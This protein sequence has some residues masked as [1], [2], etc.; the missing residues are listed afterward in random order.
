MGLL[1]GCE[2]EARMSFRYLR[3]AFSATCLIAC[4]LL[5][6]LWVRSYWRVDQLWYYK[7]TTMRGVNS[8]QGVITAYYSRT[9]L[10]P[11]YGESYWKY[12]T[13]VVSEFIN[14]ADDSRVKIPRPNPF[15]W[16][17]R[18]PNTFGV[19]FPFWLAIAIVAVFGSIPWLSW[20]FSI[21][22]LL[23]AM[24]LVAVVLGAIVYAT[25]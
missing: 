23:I 17:N 14:L 10:P 8:K 15:R 11:S 12:G 16:D 19:Q 13:E 3:I 20:H 6:V 4:V 7:S 5:I 18:L 9:Q 1:S 24:T 21:R 22:T 25:R 2:L